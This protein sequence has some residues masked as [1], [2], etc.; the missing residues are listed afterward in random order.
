[1]YSSFQAKEFSCQVPDVEFGIDYDRALVTVKVSKSGGD[2]EVYSERLFPDNRGKIV[3]ADM[4]RLLE[5]YNVKW[6]VYSLSVNIKEERVSEDASGG[7]VVTVMGER[8]ESSTVISCAANIL[9]M[10][11][12][13]W[14]SGRFLTLFDGTRQ[15]AIGWEERLSFIGTDTA[16][17]TA[18]YDDGSHRDHSVPVVASGDC[19]MIDT[20][21]HNFEVSGKKLLRY[22]VKAGTRSMAYEVRYDVEPEV[23]PVLLFW[24]S[25]GVQELAYCTGTLKQVSSFDRKQTRI[26]REK[27]TYD[28]T[29]KESFKADTGVLT[30][31]MAN[32]WREVLRSRDIKVLTVYDGLVDFGSEKAVVITSE[33]AELSDEAD[34]LPRIT[35]EYEYADRNHNI[36]DARA[37][38][39]IFDDTFDHTFN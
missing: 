7:E 16:T 5:P 1:M 22:T 20:S 18:Y 8:T 11:A 15:T 4:D 37:E 17:C 27:K 10:S 6:L 31:P 35:F 30:F 19:V 39:R 34:H 23:A 38:G 9:N 12:E 29:E 36:F 28:M 33:K 21:S 24:N 25:F 2:T 26:G 14:C 13:N 3:L 32:W